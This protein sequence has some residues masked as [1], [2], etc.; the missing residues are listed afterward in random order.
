MLRLLA[1]MTLVLTV[2]VPAGAQ[3]DDILKG[4]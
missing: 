2:A 4:L 3:F 1:A